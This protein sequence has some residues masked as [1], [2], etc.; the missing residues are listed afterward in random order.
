MGG[1]AGS[2]AREGIDLPGICGAVLLIH[3]P[4]ETAICGHIKVCIA[5]VQLCHNAGMV[6][7]YHWQWNPTFK[8]TWVRLKLAIVSPFNRAK[9][10]GV[11]GVNRILV[12]DPSW[13]LY[14]Q[15]QEPL[16]QARPF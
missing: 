11:P 10:G 3:I 12:E 15:A 8:L 4:R 16:G 5:H 14:C 2:A 7:S 6:P 1:P 9:C 13:G